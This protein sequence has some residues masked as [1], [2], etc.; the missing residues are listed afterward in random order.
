MATIANINMGLQLDNSV[1]PLVL[2]VTDNTPYGDSTTV[3]VYIKVLQPDGIEQTFGSFAL[4]LIQHNGTALNVGSVQLRPDVNREIQTGN[5]VVTVYTRMTGFDDTTTVYSFAVGYTQPELK[6]QEYFNPFAPQLKAKD[7]TTYP[8]SLTVLTRSWEGIAEG[9][10]LLPEAS[11]IS[12]LPVINGKYYNTVYHIMLSVVVQQ[13]INANVTLKDLVIKT[14]DINPV[15]NMPALLEALNELYNKSKGGCGCQSKEYADYIYAYTVYSHLRLRISNCDSQAQTMWQELQ[16][17]L[18]VTVQYDKKELTYDWMGE[19]CGC[20]EVAETNTLI[21]PVISMLGIGATNISITWGAVPNATNYIVESSTTA[22]GTYTQIYSGGN[23]TFNNTGI[24]ANATRFYRVKAQAPGWTDSAWSSLGTATTPA[25]QITAL[26]GW[27]DDNNVSTALITNAQG[28]GS[29]TDQGPITADYRSN[30]TPKWLYMLEPNTQPLKTVWF[31]ST[32]NQGPIS[33]VNDSGVFRYRGTVA[34]GG[35]TY[36][37][38]MTTALRQES[39]TT[40]QF[41][42]S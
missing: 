28:T 7:I 38:Y 24:G 25:A 11:G 15:I 21:S 12:Y 36:N 27:A 23:T 8:N 13:T 31:G 39:T 35:I 17:L 22:N 1:S 32:I 19:H 3:K 14:F 37:V 29:F 18:G 20:N 33:V 34:Q 40:I 2:R 6:V 9:I 30:L 42:V 41:R 10:G 5:Y 16:Q 4:P 26:W